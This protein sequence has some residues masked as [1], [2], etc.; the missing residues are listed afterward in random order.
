ML[1]ASNHNNFTHWYTHRL[2]AALRF[3]DVF[4]SRPVET[5]LKVTI[6]GLD[7]TAVRCDNDSTYRFMVT[8]ARVPS[9]TFQVVVEDPEKIYVNHQLIELTL[10]AAS[11]T[12]PISRGDFL[13]EYPLWPTRRYKIPPGETAVVGRLTSTSSSDVENLEV[14]IYPAGQSPPDTPFACSDMDGEFLYRLPDVVSD[15]NGDPRPANL[16]V[17]VQREGAAVGPV[18]PSSFRPIP[19]RMCTITFV[20]P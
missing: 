8:E 1:D 18:T 17:Q 10:P 3:F 5:P 12:P 9:G 4:T 16:A 11:A 13:H 14:R 6:P 7:W 19:G 2:A 20:I 15:T